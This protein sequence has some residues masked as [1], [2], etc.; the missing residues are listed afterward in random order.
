MNLLW[1][2]QQRFLHNASH[3]QNWSFRIECQNLD[4][5]VFF[6]LNL[7]PSRFPVWHFGVLPS[8]ISYHGGVSCLRLFGN[9]YVHLC[10]L[11]IKAR[12]KCVYVYLRSIE[13]RSEH[14]QNI[15]SWD[16]RW[17]SPIVYPCFTFSSQPLHDA[18]L[19][20][21][22]FSNWFSVYKAKV[23]CLYIANNHC[24]IWDKYA[25]IFFLF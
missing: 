3:D 18:H 6:L 11:A 12:Q 19:F 25:I 10:R 17:P 16:Q 22:F 2:I 9:I 8:H 1:S 13:I 5:E 14:L 21:L 4:T 23:D 20:L 24:R 15:S 7:F